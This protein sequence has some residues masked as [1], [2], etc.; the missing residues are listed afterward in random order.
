MNEKFITE[1]HFT[2]KNCRDFVN[3]VNIH[4][5]I[6]VYLL[7]LV[8]ISALEYNNNHSWE[9]VFM[10]IVAMVIMYFFSSFISSLI[11]VKRNGNSLKLRFY[12]RHMY[13]ETDNNREK[14][15][16]ETINK[17]VERDDYF[18][19]FFTKHRGAFIIE[20]KGFSKGNIAKF[21]DFINEH[22]PKKK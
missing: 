9:R 12:E 1:T 2:K 5:Q 21:S 19:L 15:T 22:I 13:V 16:Y 6:W 8:L 11:L 10:F 4:R 3:Y 20:K 17:L 18:Y 14:I 7:V